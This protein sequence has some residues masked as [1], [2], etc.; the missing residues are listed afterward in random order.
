[1]TVADTFDLL[2]TARGGRGMLTREAT[3]AWLADRQ[4]SMLDPGWVSALREI[5]ERPSGPQP[6]G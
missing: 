1:V 2:F 4:G 3:A 6:P 5:L